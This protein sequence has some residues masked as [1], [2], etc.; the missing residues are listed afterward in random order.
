MGR[1]LQVVI[2]TLGNPV[3]DNST[4]D[5]QYDV[6]FVPSARHRSA[7]A[8]FYSRHANATGSPKVSAH[9][10]HALNCPPIQGKLFR[11]HHPCH[12]VSFSCS[13]WWVLHRTCAVESQS[14]WLLAQVEMMTEIC[15]KAVLLTRPT[16]RML[17]SWSHQ[18]V[19][20]RT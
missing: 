6:T 2:L 10:A 5:L 7:T 15:G 20:K 8:D 1:I 11:P 4:N 19:P 18:H 9:T 16:S 12:R 14:L 13:G 3:F 17:E